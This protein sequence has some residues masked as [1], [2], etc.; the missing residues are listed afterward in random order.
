MI[1][2]DVQTCGEIAIMKTIKVSLTGTWE[3]IKYLFFAIRMD[4]RV[5]SIKR[6]P[7][8]TEYTVEMKPPKWENRYMK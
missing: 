1:A 5:V 2:K 3:T 4:W 7:R 6:I 8:P